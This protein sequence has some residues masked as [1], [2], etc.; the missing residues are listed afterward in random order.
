[1]LTR[2]LIVQLL[3]HWEKRD[4]YA[5]IILDAALKKHKLSTTDSA[6]VQ[7]IFYGVIRWL[8]KLEWMVK[9]FFQG[10]LEKSPRFVRHILLIS[11][12]QLFYLDRIPHYAVIN[13]AVEMA[14]AKGGKYWAGKVNAILRNFLKNK[15][16]IKLPDLASLPIEHISINYSF[17]EWLVQRWIEQWGIDSTVALCEAANERPAISLRVNRLKITAS[18]LLEK[19]IALNIEAKQSAFNENFIKVYSIPNLSNFQLF[20]Q[21]YFSIQDES[22]GLACQLLNP[23]PGEKI[24]DLCAAPGGKTGYLLELSRNQALMFA[25]D[26]NFSRL[27]LV[28]ENLKRL[29]FTIHG[30]IQADGRQFNC[31]GIDKIL[32]DAPCSGLGVL[33]K[34]VDLRW[35]RT[36]D[37]ILELTQIQFELLQHAADL[38]QSGGTIVYSTCTI[39]PEENEAIVEKFLARQQNF[40]IETAANYVSKEFTTSQGFVRTFPQTHKMDGSFAVRLVKS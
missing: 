20:Q 1:M 24:V 9:Q 3:D 17:P 32:L 31:C 38:I 4:A 18:E 23:Q 14:K 10:R 7:E 34:R 5:D 6:L 33:A 39:D 36:A 37:Q 21:G 16:N 11:F 40:K 8:K 28:N 15:N 22:A 2:Q 26:Q 30:F 12:F 19:L 35:R 27:N 25:V 29:N 13:E